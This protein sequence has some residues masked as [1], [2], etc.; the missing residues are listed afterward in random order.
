MIWI[1]RNK[2]TA[3]L[4]DKSIVNFKVN[5]NVELYPATKWVKPRKKSKHSFG[6]CHAFKFQTKEQAIKVFI[7]IENIL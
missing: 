7:E 5:G 6:Y 3:L 2:E 1:D 4:K